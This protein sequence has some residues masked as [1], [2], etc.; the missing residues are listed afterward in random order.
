MITR[1]LIVLCPNCHSQFD[2]FYFA[3]DL[4]TRAVHCIFEEDE[5]YHQASLN[6][7]HELDPKYLEYAW[8][9]FNKKKKSIQ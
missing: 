9:I 8:C 2:D 7:V 3:I 4:E 5:P 1:N 6:I